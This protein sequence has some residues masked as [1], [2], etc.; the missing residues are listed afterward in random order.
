V[1]DPATA[2]VTG[3]SSGIGAAIARRL[4]QAGHKTIFCGRDVARL[5]AAA[6][7]G[8][9][10]HPLRLDMTDAA[11]IAALPGSLPPEF[12]QVGILVNAAGHDVGGR[13]PFQ[14]GAVEDWATIIDTNLTGVLRLTHTLLKGMLARGGGDVV[15]VGSLATIRPAGRLAAYAAS[16][17]GL[18]AFSDALRADVSARG[19]RVMEVL[20]GLTRTGF[21][22]ARLR[23]DTAAPNRFYDKIDTA[24][25]A[26]DV[27][28]AV[29]A[30]L[31]Q[32]RHVV[33]A[34]LVL[35]PP[36]QF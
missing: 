27:A 4:A 26:D 31:A 18:H 34:Q 15:I 3:A 21:A 24:L 35:T 14:D 30:A 29:L 19:I 16:K 25:T 32:P 11:A 8:P 1:T 23:G 20:P 28:G 10:V 33:T 6:G 12:R 17:A 7:L 22:E 13:R 36:S 9:L 2:L 5:A